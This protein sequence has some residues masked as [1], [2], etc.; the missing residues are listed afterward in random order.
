[1]YNVNLSSKAKKGYETYTIYRGQID[2]VLETLENNPFPF[3]DF[4]L[5]KLKGMED[6]FRIRIGKMRIKYRLLEADKAIIVFYIG[7]RET[8]YD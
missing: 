8:A 3:R 6:S 4:D 5:A 1:M 2:S 7:P